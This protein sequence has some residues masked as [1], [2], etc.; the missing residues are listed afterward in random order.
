M[1]FSFDLTVIAVGAALA[2]RFGVLAATLPLVDMRTVPPLWRAAL[3]V[4]LGASLAPAVTAQL[5]AFPDPLT[6]QVA[7]AEGVRSLVVGAMLGFTVNLVFTAVRVAGTIAGMQVGFAI[8]NS[9]DPTTQSQVSVLGQLYYLLT[10]LLFFAT[11][12]HHILVGAMVRSC[13]IL[14]PFSGIQTAGASWFLLQEFGEVFAV[15][16]RIAAPVV[17]VL[18]LVSSAMGVIV[19]TVPQLNI[20]VVGFPIK[21]G[22]GVFVFGLSLVYFKEVVLGQFS[23]LEGMLNGVMLALR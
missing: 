4:C 19:K 17:L 14:P 13:E 15:G 2:L 16:L 5:P 6:W 10:V 3:A 22:V 20:L 21:I 12:T 1:T 9:F 18:L 7:L 11:G 8:V 23:G